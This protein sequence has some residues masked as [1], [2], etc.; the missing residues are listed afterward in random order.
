MNSMK[1]VE[2]KWIV[3]KIYTSRNPN[4]PNAIIKG[5][6]SVEIQSEWVVLT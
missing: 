2:V 4:F 5:G 1:L 6:A 3:G